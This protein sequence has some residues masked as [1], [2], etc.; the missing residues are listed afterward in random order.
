[1]DEFTGRMMPGR[2][3]SHGIHQ[4]VEA[5]ENVPIQRESLTYATITFQNY[6]R[7]YE[8]LAGMTGTAETEAEEF[9]KIYAL[10]VVVIPTNRAMVRADHE[11]M[12]YIN[13]K[14]KF[15]AVVEEIVG[16]HGQRRPVLVGTTSIEKSE[17]LSALLRR[18]GIDHEVLNAKQHEREANIVETAGEPGAVVIAT[19][20]AGRGT[21]IKLGEGVASAG[22]LHVVG[23]ERHESRRIDNQLRGRS[24]R[25]GDPGS[26]RFFVSFGD[27]I[28]QR[29]APGLGAGDAGEDGDDGGS[30]PRVAHGDAR[31]RAGPAEGRGLQL[32]HPQ[33]PGRV[34]RRDGTAS[35]SDRPAGA[36]A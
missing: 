33:A 9:A 23:T 1:M 17:Y 29:F 10:D 4:A 14:A 34:R 2:R 31:H 7:L 22:G 12:V 6:F 5:K 28:M 8:K 30:A 27:D 15:A 18:R 21:D 20:M 25:Q 36:A 35:V 16:M 24:G 13:E 11:D 3:W 26:S 19:N 32:R